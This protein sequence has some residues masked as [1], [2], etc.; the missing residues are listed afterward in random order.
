MQPVGQL[1]QNHPNV[2]RKRQQ[3]FTEILRLLRR[4]IFK[5]AGYFGQAV[6]DLGDFFTK[7]P[8]NVLDTH[9]RILDNVMQQCRHDT[10]CTQP[11]LFNDDLCNGQRVVYIGF[12]R[13][14][15]HVFMRVNGSIKSFFD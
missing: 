5:P 10:G 8:L 9:V 2:I 6:N 11:D 13:P 15:T 7:Q 3:H 4:S 14:A 12:S 1:H